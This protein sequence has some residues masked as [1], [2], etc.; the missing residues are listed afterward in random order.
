MSENCKLRE[1]NGEP[2]RLCDGG[3][4]AFWRVV[5]HVNDES[6]SGCAIQHYELIG[7][8]D[9]SAWLLSV[10]ERLTRQDQ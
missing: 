9:V 1:A 4:C 8:T 5:E 3:A 6:G 2:G 10:K 7:D